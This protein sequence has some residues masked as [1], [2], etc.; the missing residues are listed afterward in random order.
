MNIKAVR[1]NERLKGIA[2]MGDN[3]SLAL[4]IAAVV[5]GL[6]DVNI[7]VGLDVIGGFVLMGAAWHVRGKLQPEE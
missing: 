1:L 7:V 4:F 2:G 3:G 5:Q 6:T